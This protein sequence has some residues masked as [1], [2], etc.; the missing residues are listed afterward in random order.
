MG[1]W[2]DELG[3]KYIMKMYQCFQDDQ[4]V[5]FE[6]EP[7]LGCTLMSQIIES[8]KVVQCNAC[9]Y[10]AELILALEH[11]HS[12]GIIYRNLRPENIILANKR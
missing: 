9:F 5:Y 6:L 3:V 1:E 12:Y 7:V 8:N 11:L 4:N 10:A 2:Q